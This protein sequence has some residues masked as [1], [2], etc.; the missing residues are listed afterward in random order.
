MLTGP[1]Q[2]GCSTRLVYC[3]LVGPGRDTSR[4]DIAADP[5]AVQ[6]PSTFT[7]YARGRRRA[8]RVAAC[9]YG[10]VPAGCQRECLER[11]NA[12]CRLVASLAATCGNWCAGDPKNFQSPYPFRVIS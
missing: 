10:S 8:V 5:P 11:E 12:L 7:Q 1:V 3:I 4:A 2:P 9:G 6:L